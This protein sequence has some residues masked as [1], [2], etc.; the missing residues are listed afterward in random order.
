MEDT[1][2]VIGHEGTVSEIHGNKATVRFIVQSAC[3]H[4][5]LKGVCSAADMKD[6][7]VE[8]DLQ[9]QPYRVGEKVNVVLS[10]SKGM[11]ALLYGYLLPFLL[12]MITLFAV[13]GVTGD[14]IASGLASLAVLVPYYGGLYLLR[15][16][17]R[18]EFRFFVRKLV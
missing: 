3:A 11:K 2:K 4:C 10:Q 7:A 5:Q 9:G 1:P 15:S 17:I 14:E 13:Y 18:R 6:K 12:V 8:A 16:R